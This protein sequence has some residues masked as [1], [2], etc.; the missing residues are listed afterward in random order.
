[1]QHGYDVNRFQV[2]QPLLLVYVLHAA[3]ASSHQQP[4]QTLWLSDRQSLSGPA[5]QC[6]LH[7]VCSWPA[8]HA[9]NLIDH[10]QAARWHG[11]TRTCSNIR[12]HPMASD[13]KRFGAQHIH[14]KEHQVLGIGFST[15]LACV[16]ACFKVQH[17]RACLQQLSWLIPCSATTYMLATNQAQGAAG[18]VVH[19]AAHQVWGLGCPVAHQVE[20][21]ELP[22][23]P[24]S[25]KPPSVSNLG[26]WMCSRYCVRHQCSSSPLLGDEG[27]DRCVGQGKGG[28]EGAQDESHK[29][30]QHT[31]TCTL[32]TDSRPVRP[33]GGVTGQRLVV[34]LVV[35]VL[36][37]WTRRKH[38]V[39]M[40]PEPTQ[41]HQG[42]C[43]RLSCK[44]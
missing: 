27:L 44:I 10:L 4:Q 34:A 1:M 40:I 12:Q 42:Q 9:D 7:H 38:R 24:H 32:H 35:H 41:G 5:H 30:L 33:A 22:R 43:P 13:P 29:W 26:V 23:V 20:G 19:H 31:N 36:Q 37:A 21:F 39:A 8:V 25:R 15:V 28:V 17:M 11:S 14:H 3:A 18:Q 6:V 16:A 2:T